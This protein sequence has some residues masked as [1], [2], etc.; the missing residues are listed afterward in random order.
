MRQAAGTLSGGQQQMLAMATAYVRSPRLI[1]IDEASLGLAPLIV[2][3]IFQFMEKIAREG[4]A[5]L[6]VDQF[7]VRALALAE[8]AYVL[9]RGTI[10]YAGPARD[11]GQAE[12]LSQYMGV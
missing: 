10:R 12:L 3:Q 2:D 6:I 11:L 1:L 4:T 8:T 7:A 5:L 9:S